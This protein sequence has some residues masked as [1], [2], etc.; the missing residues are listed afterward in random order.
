MLLLCEYIG[1]YLMPI[2]LDL[3]LEEIFVGRHEELNRLRK[4]WEQTLKP[5][6]HF[7]YVVLN[8][9]GTGKTRLLSYFGELLEQEQRG[10]FF[11]YTC[12]SRHTRASTLCLDIITQLKRQ[13]YHKESYIL[14]YLKKITHNTSLDLERKKRKCRAYYCV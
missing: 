4:I 12:R 8:A 10:L 1:G 3:D 6:E 5:R 13:L 14:E 11:R 2:T 9:P 7:V